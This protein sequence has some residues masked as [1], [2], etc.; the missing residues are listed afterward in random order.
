V[1]PEVHGELPVDVLVACGVE[2]AGLLAGRAVV[3]GAVKPS[4][5]LLDAVDG[6]ADARA[7]SEVQGNGVGDAAVGADLGD[8]TV[9]GSGAAGGEHDGGALPGEEP[10]RGRADAAA[11]AGDKHHLASEQADGRGAGVVCHAISV[12]GP[13]TRIQAQPVLR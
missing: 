6:G 2:G 7:V 12:R 3:E 8:D 1:S 5:Q 13:G 9:E 10:G 11:C 4:V